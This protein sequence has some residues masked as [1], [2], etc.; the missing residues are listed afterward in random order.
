[1]D[2]SALV[3]LGLLVALAIAAAVVIRRMTQIAAE[4][5]K[6]RAYVDGVGRVTAAADAALDRGSAAVD[7]LL[8]GRGTTDTTA[9]EVALAAVELEE[10]R[11]QLVSLPAPDSLAEGNRDLT[12]ALGA[13]SEALAGLQ[14]NLGELQPGRPA[15]D[16][17]RLEAGRA[18]RRAL[19]A[20]LEARD[21]VHVAERRIEAS[22]AT[23]RARAGRRG[24]AAGR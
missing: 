23:A 24:R 6:L 10:A 8:H 2:I 3:S 18:T 21:A 12:T 1:M 22:V 5:R 4:E 7:G 16:P 20:T 17:A 13:G 19:L 15:D 11:A 9:D 14:P